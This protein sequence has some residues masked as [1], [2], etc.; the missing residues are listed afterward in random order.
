MYLLKHFEPHN[1][2]LI[3]TIIEDYPFATVISFDEKNEPFFS[4]LPL[5]MS[6]S[7]KS[8]ILLGHLARQNP[9]WLH[10]RN[11]PKIKVLIHGPH[12]YITPTWFR[13]GRD[14]PTWNYVAIHIDGTAKL[15]EDF[16]GLTSILEVLTKKFEKGSAKPWELE[17]PT[18]L[19]T[20]ETLCAA[21]VGFQIQIDKIEAKFK[22]SQNRSLEDKRGVVEGLAARTDDMSREIRQLMMDISL[23][24]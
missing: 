12:T 16:K 24:N 4:H 20:P 14:V 23:P 15:V 17:L 9:Q 19:L 3:E 2:K 8:F 13:S 6:Q 21:I 5:I 1:E 10:F 7:E 22:L 11:N 18:D